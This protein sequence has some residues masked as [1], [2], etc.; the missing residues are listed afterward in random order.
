MPRQVGEDKRPKARSSE[1]SEKGYDFLPE[2]MV[3]VIGRQVKMAE[4]R[5]ERGCDVCS[6]Y[7]LKTIVDDGQRSEKM[8]ASRIGPSFADQTERFKRFL[9]VPNIIDDGHGE[10]LRE[11]FASRH[12]PSSQNIVN[13]KFRMS[14]GLA[15]NVNKEKNTVGAVCVMVERK[16]R[17]GQLEQR[18]R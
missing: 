4:E 17:Y 16:S 2:L 3:I 9:V 10:F 18:Q 11:V 5:R 12:D 15:R 13:N 14:V 1:V 6:L 8:I 7:L